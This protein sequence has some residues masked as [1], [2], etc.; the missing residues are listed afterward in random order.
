MNCSLVYGIVV[1]TLDDINFAT[2]RPV[3]A[4]GPE[5][6]I[7]LNTMRMSGKIWTT[8]LTA[9]FHSPEAYGSH[10]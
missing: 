7:K 10:P 3:R 5:S 4:V 2:S 6:A 8:A 1:Y 9:M